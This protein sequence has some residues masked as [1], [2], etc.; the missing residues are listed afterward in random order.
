MRRIR[1][2]WKF[3]RL[4]STNWFTDPQAEVAKV[5]DAYERAV[6]ASAPEPAPPT[7]PGHDLEPV[8]RP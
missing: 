8:K 4:W 2:G 5:R 7:A 1:L 3:H 6:S